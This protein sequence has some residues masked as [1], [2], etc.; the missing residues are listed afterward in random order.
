MTS[1]AMDFIENFQ[2]E[3]VLPVIEFLTYPRKYKPWLSTPFGAQFEQVICSL[4]VFPIANGF[5][6]KFVCC[7][8]VIDA[9]HNSKVPACDAEYA[10]FILFNM[11]ELY[12]VGHY[13]FLC[14]HELRCLGNGVLALLQMVSPEKYGEFHGMANHFF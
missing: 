2:E 1:E 7:G 4:E 9:V 8:K 10:L 11:F 6:I 13:S 5:S 3:L 14:K 12:F